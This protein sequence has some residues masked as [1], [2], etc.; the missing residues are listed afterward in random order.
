MIWENSQSWSRN[1]RA[2]GLVAL[3]VGGVWTLSLAVHAQQATTEPPRSAGVPLPAAAV[4]QRAVGDAPL[5]PDVSATH[6]SQSELVP[7]SSDRQD[8]GSHQQVRGKADG[9]SQAFRH[10][11]RKILPAVVVI[12]GEG[13]SA[14]P[15]CGRVHSSS[16]EEE[17][18]ADESDE[19]PGE[20]ARDSLRV[21][22]SGFIIDPSGLVLT[23]HH[24]VRGARG[25][26]V[27]L[28]DKQQFR[29]VQAKSNA[30]LDLAVLKVACTSPLPTASLADS[31]DVEIGDW[32]L[33]IGCPLELE[34]TVSAGIISAKNRSMCPNH[35]RRMIQTDAVI[36]PGSSGG[37]LVNLDARVVGITTS[38]KSEDGGYQ[39]I[40]FAIP[41]AYATKLI[42]QFQEAANTK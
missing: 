27:Q 4:G 26:V 18:P 33:A 41:A 3:A 29:V 12:R 24:V 16:S 22:G 8:A 30:E 6:P 21:L 15:H 14:C 36:N 10:A 25:V 1:L 39:G 17:T 11:A 40:G 5:S 20:E 2:L 7:A 28:P 42:A 9:L 32:V 35:N 37:P 13:S 23:N 38:I 31:D 19:V 34:Q